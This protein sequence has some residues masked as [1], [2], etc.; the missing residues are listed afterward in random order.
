M[1]WIERV[2]ASL[3]VM[4]CRA[5]AT[6]SRNVTLARQREERPREPILQSGAVQ[7]IHRFR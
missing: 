7:T 6:D 4:I 5:L 3:T 2:F 1:L